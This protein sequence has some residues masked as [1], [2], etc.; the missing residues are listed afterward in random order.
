M[1]VELGNAKLLRH[2]GNVVEGCYTGQLFPGHLQSV[3]DRLRIRKLLVQVKRKATL[4]VQARSMATLRAKRKLAQNHTVRKIKKSNEESIYSPFVTAGTLDGNTLVTSGYL[5]KDANT[6]NS[7]LFLLDD[8]E[9]QT[10]DDTFVKL[11]GP[12]S[13]ANGGT[14]DRCMK[15]C[16]F[17]GM[18]WQLE[19]TVTIPDLIL[20]ARARNQWDLCKYR[21][22]ARMLK[23]A[24]FGFDEVFSLGRKILVSPLHFCMDLFRNQP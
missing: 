9:D 21:D 22:A 15:K 20:E 10:Q 12:S 24:E 4:T 7:D 1:L 18:A 13:A 16:L 14:Q 2:Q 6:D 5:D 19:E 17:L 23:A 3:Q 11:S 8:D